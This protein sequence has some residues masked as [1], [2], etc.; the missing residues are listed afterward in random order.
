MALYVELAVA[1][2]SIG[3]GGGGI[4]GG[5]TMLGTLR[6]SDGLVPLFPDS[7]CWAET[8][9]FTKESAA[10]AAAATWLRMVVAASPSEFTAG[11]TSPGTDLAELSSLLLE[12][13]LCRWFR[14]AQ[15]AKGKK[16]RP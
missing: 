9:G 12:L 7:A 6:F 13:L 3:G 8:D 11:C 14:F 2:T 5:F 10:A 4:V 1:S 16:S 15:L